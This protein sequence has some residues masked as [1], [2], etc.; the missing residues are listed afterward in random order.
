MKPPRHRRHR[1][2]A[3]AALLL[4]TMLA[5]MPLR[6]QTSE[7]ELKAEIVFRALLFVQWP[8]RAMTADQAIQFCVFDDSPLALALRA[9]DGR[10][11]NSHLFQW[12]QVPI[13]QSTVC[14][15]AYV[16]GVLGPVALTQS[17]GRSIFWVSDELGMLE[18]GAMF[19]LQIDNGRVVFDIGLGSLRR[20][21]LDISAKVLRMARYVKER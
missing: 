13:E 14:H 21:G 11:I 18:R 6:A 17:P 20:A 10:R 8:P 5:A 15:A 19:N 12:R 16:G 2:A 3:V 7:P 4:T 9:L 1:F